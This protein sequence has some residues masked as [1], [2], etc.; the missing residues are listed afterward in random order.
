MFDADRFYAATD[1]AMRFIASYQTLAHW[2][3]REIGPAFH[4]LGGRILYKGADLNAFIESRRVE[5]TAA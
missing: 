4:R 1:P 2:R 3:A 5:P